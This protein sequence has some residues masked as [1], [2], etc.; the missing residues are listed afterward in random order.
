VDQQQVVEERRRKDIITEQNEDLAA[1]VPLAAELSTPTTPVVAIETVDDDVKQDTV[2]DKVSDVE[3]ALVPAQPAAE[4]VAEPQY[5]NLV[6]NFTVGVW[7][8]K[9]DENAS[10]YRC[11]LAAII[12]GTGKYIFVN[13]S[14][15]KVAEETRDTLAM[16]LQK[17]KLRTL[18]DSML[19]DRA[20]ESVITSLRQPR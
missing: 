15:I 16:Q 18:D 3:A 20:L 13:R 19:F 2:V 4:P 17:G 12:R 1:S 8:E 6:D 9:I 10:P 11:R 14:G 5:L 7:F